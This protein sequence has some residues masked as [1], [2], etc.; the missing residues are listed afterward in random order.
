MHCS[1]VPWGKAAASRQTAL[2]ASGGPVAAS[3]GA[4]PHP[5]Y[6]SAG[7]QPRG[8]NGAPCIGSVGVEQPP[9]FWQ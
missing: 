9:K 3:G 1:L 7:A 6:P 5:E 8:D 2:M 4:V